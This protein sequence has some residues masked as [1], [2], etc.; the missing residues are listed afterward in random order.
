MLVVMMMAMI[1]MMAVIMIFAFKE[2]RLD[3][4]DAIEIES[5]AA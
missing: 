2:I 4:E 1:V 3:F 5:V